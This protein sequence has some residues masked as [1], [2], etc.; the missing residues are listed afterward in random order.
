MAM[1]AT[2][3]REE[4]WMYVDAASGQQRGPLPVRLLKRLIRKGH[5][6]PQHLVWTQR[7]NEWT[8]AAT[9]EPFE[10]YCRIWLSYWY[11]MIDGNPTQQGPVST[12]DLMTLFLDGEID[13]LT[14]VWT[15]D[16]AQWTPMGELPS[17]KEFVHEANEDQ[18]RE[19]EVLA[20]Q[21]SAAEEDQVFD[22]ASVQVFEAEDGKKYVFDAET[23]KWVTPEEKIAEDLEALR[24]EHGK[25]HDDSA[26]IAELQK[27]AQATKLPSVPSA[28]TAAPPTSSELVDAAST[29]P[30]QAGASEDQ[31]KR[32]K[33][34]KK[35][36]SKGER[37]QKAKSN[38][39]VYVNGLP[40]DVT[41][42]E[43][44]DH[45][46][47]CGVIQTDLITGAPRIKLYRN[48]DLGGLNGD[49]SVCFM[50]EAS[51]ELAVQ[52]LDKSQIRPEWTI[53][54]SPAVFEQKG[55]E[56]VKHKKPRLDSRARV[57]R[58]EQEKALSWNEGDDGDRAGLRIV[59]IKHMFTPDE[60]EDDAY[61]L[62]LKQ[63]IEEECSKMGEIT[64][65]TM[66]S[67]HPDGVVVIK[68][69]SAGSAAKC[70]EVM[71]GRF[72]AG[73]KLVSHFW[74][75]ADYTHRES[76]EEEKKRAEK[77]D[78]W[79]NEGS[80]SSEE[81]D[82]GEE[83]DEGDDEHDTQGDSAGHTHQDGDVHAGRVLPDLD[84]LEDDDSD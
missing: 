37:W 41:L 70:V 24:D 20:Q 83:D 36:K 10:S 30:A 47:K 65:V 28:A 46:T 35:K 19:A 75:G 81:E 60:I 79:L 38:T 58:L 27:L 7:L 48:K 43:V 82:G 53:D 5:V 50:K 57:K 42:E 63:E 16:M 1:P 17:L 2:T 56:Y 40:L 71:N 77:F 21:R 45:F 34:R 55:A 54:V 74:D 29:T 3:A 15:K 8:P 49:A 59:V 22:D 18:E 72:F 61:E 67:K 62:E 68:F 80:S 78:E 26:D 64:K 76:K 4:L 69:A 31:A 23:K 25:Q 51:V 39:W 66:F 52:L 84:T 44:R 12:K 9:T 6:T 14:L 73:R 13:G 33:K 32:E 11:Y